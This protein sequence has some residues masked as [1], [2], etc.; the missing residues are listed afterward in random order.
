M[1]LFDRLF[2]SRVLWPPV[3]L[4]HMV[5]GFLVPRGWLPSP[6]PY[7]WSTGFIALPR[8]VGRMPSHRERPALPMVTRFH[9]AFETCPSDASPSHRTRRT[10][11]DESFR[12]V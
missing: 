4:P 12:S 5:F 8:T 7:G 3:T 6:P 1:N 9:S 2:G 11:P 10:S